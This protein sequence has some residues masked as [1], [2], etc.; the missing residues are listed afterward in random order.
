MG[1][2][3]CGDMASYLGIHVH[4]IGSWSHVRFRHLHK[5]KV[6]KGVCVDVF[7]RGDAVANKRLTCYDTEKTVLTQ[8]QV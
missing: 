2:V 6:L 5:T 8:I 3:V 7:C 1:K 4:D